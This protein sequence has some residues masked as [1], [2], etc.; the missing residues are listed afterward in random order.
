MGE[1]VWCHDEEA[2]IDV[3]DDQSND[4]G[5]PASQGVQG[6]EGV[7]ASQPE[8]QGTSRPS[9]IQGSDSDGYDDIDGDD[10]ASELRESCSETEQQEELGELATSAYVDRAIET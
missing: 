4:G 10:V 1:W 7:E 2:V 5:G 3:D 9:L 6:G 8:S